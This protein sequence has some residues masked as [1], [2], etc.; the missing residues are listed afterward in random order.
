METLRSAVAEI[1][2]HALRSVLTLTGIVLG[3][4]ALVVMSSV[5]DGVTGAVSEGFSD[6]G[7]DG[8]FAVSRR[9][10][11]TSEERLLFAQS[12]GLR[13]DDL[14]ALRKSGRE[15]SGVSGRAE[16]SSIVAGN[17]RAYACR[18]I[19]VEPDYRW[20][21]NRQPAEGRFFAEGDLLAGTRVCVI[22]STLRERLFGKGEALGQEINLG[23]VRLRVIGVGR[24][25]GNSWFR[26]GMFREEMEGVIVPLRT[27]LRDFRGGGPMDMIEIKA[28]DP[29]DVEA[30]I[31]EVNRILLAQHRVRD[32]RV[33]N[34]SAEILQSRGQ[35][36]EQVRNWRIVMLSIA[37]IT[38]VVGGVGLLSVLL[39]SLAERTYEIGLRKALGATGSDIFALFLTESLLLAT[40]GAVLGVALGAGVTLLASGGFP[41]GLQVSSGGVMIAV[42]AALTVG[43]L[44]GIGPSLRASAMAPVE[45]LREKG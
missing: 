37:G 31:A 14:D 29:D 21:R 1:A 5:M 24:P 6:L 44:F 2:Q 15:L 39:I 26:E 45:C 16:A 9:T 33:E 13:L 36:S 25:L 19:G 12:P 42:G 35:A 28:R 20:M 4:L 34:I 10:P 41:D 7:F 17:G 27:L 43:L 32:F 11:R 23:D 8:V 40:L 3:C 30:A 18:V 22:G 38:L